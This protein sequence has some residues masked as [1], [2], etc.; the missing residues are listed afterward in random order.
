MPLMQNAIVKNWIVDL[1]LAGSQTLKKT[2][3]EVTVT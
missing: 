2:Q 3:L 1:P